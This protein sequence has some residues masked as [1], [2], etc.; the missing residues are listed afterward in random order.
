MM[1]VEVDSTLVVAGLTKTMLGCELW[2]TSVATIVACV[3]GSALSWPLH[4]AYASNTTLS[5]T[6]L[7]AHHYFFGGKTHL[8]RLPLCRTQFCLLILY[9]VRLPPQPYIPL[10]YCSSTGS[11]K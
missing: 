8:L 5:V 3:L 6:K 10:C 1:G 2:K 9:I 11:L 4:I 7:R